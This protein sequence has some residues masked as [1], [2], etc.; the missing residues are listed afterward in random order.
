MFTFDTDVYDL[1]FKG[2]KIIIST[3]IAIQ[4][5]LKNKIIIVNHKFKFPLTEQGFVQAINKLN[6]YL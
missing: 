3:K 6:Y 5:D 2:F 4:G 1:I